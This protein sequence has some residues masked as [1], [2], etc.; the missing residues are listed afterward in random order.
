M[1][2]RSLLALLSLAL[3]APV[4]A[5]VRDDAR[6]FPWAGVRLGGAWGASSASG[7]VPGAGGGGAYALFDA[8]DYLA[9]FSLDLFFGDR[10]HLVDAGLGAYYPFSHGN[11]TPYLGGGVKLGWTKFGGDGTFGMIPFAAL[12]VLL[13]R[14][15]FPQLR[16]ELS[17][18]LASSR[19][20][21]PKGGAGTRASG[22]M[23]TLGISF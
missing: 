17:Y 13:G 20:Q 1:R 22:P 8:G 16:L 3:A 2:I 9:D 5:E 12:G 15:E 19:E 7:G 21:G 23:A 18:F 6:A 14:T 4:R 11:V 10:T